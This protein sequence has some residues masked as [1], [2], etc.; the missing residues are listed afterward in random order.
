MAAVAHQGRIHIQRNLS[1]TDTLGTEKQFV[2]QR[3]P[4]FRGYFTRTAIYLDPQK[5]SAIERFSLLGELLIEVPLYCVHAARSLHDTC[6]HACTHVCMFVYACTHVR[7]HVC[8]CIHTCRHVCACIH[9][10]M[11]THMYLC[12]FVHAH[13]HVRMHTHMYVYTHV[14][15]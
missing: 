4:L 14:C 1:I 13:T 9:T 12:M 6:V 7:M 3:F 11:H 15:R 2:I 10:C 8:I 5:Q